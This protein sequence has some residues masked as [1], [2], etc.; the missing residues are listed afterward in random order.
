MPPAAR[1]GSAPPGG[2]GMPSEMW[3]RPQAAK[4]SATVPTTR[5]F[6]TP[7]SFGARRKY[8]PKA[9]RTSGTAY[10]TR[11]RVP[12]TTAWMTSPTTPWTPHHSRA[13]TTTASPM[14]ANPTPSRRCSGS[15]SRGGAA[16]AA[17]RSAGQVRDAH[18]GAADGPQRQRKPAGAG[19]RGAAGGRLA[20]G[21]AAAAA[22]R[23]AR[24]RHACRWTGATTWRTDGRPWSNRTR[25]SPQTHASHAPQRTCAVEPPVGRAPISDRGERRSPWNGRGPRYPS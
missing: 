25:K 3:A 11:P 4:V 9:S 16:D 6:V 15:R 10:P 17:D 1:M 20:R 12:A 7:S 23:L 18:P 14:R 24:R 21:R 5:R 8:R 2:F 19:L 22:R 13:A